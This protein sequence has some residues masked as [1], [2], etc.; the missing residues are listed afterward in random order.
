VPASCSGA[1]GKRAQ[2]VDI[3][4]ADGIAL[5]ATQTLEKFEGGVYLSY[6]LQGSVHVTLHQVSGGDAMLNGVFFDAAS[7]AAKW[8]KSDD[9]V[10]R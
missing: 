5:A 2:T 6:E 3:L 7:E 9:N 8:L 10:R 1:S 4:S